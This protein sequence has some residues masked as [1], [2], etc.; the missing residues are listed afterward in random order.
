MQGMRRTSTRSVLTKSQVLQI[1][2]Y[3]EKTTSTSYKGELSTAKI[4]KIYGV[5]EKAIRD[6]WTAR[7]WFRET[8]PLEP[9]RPKIAERLTRRP[10]RPKGSKDR[11]QRRKRL[12]LFQVNL[13]I[14]L[15]SR[16]LQDHN[17]SSQG[18]KNKGAL[19]QTTLPIFKLDPEQPITMSAPLG[20][21]PFITQCYDSL[22]SSESLATFSQSDTPPLTLRTSATSDRWCVPQTVS[23]PPSSTTA[24]GPSPALDA[25]SWLPMAPSASAAAFLDPFRDDWPHWDDAPAACPPDGDGPGGGPAAAPAWGHSLP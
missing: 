4:A 1:F 11:T 20:E 19:F 10:G 2:A 7:T 15:W 5:T 12:Y 22:G 23:K 3:K 18:T 9:S 6:I 14:E 25:F 17:H 16:S 21:L 13:P 24:A 8:L